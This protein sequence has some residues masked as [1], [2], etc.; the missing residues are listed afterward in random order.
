L[1]ERVQ[2]VGRENIVW[3]ECKPGAQALEGDRIKGCNILVKVW[4]EHGFLAHAER[5]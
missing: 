4:D 5:K 3:F 1:V 2:V